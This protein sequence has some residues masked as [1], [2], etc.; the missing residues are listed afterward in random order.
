MCFSGGD[1]RESRFKKFRQDLRFLHVLSVKCDYLPRSLLSEVGK[2]RHL[3]YKLG[4][5]RSI[6]FVELPHTLTNLDSLLTLDVRQCHDELILPNV[7]SKMEQLKH[8]LLPIVFNSL[9]IYFPIVCKVTRYHPIEVSLP[10][11]IT[12]AVAS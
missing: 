9:H 2:L 8:I 1:L 12:W 11:L 6:E 7:I 4:S 10:N 5:R 3:P